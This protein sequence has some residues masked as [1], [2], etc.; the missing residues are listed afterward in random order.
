VGLTVDFS[1]L[2]VGW[3]SQ[4]SR[5]APKNGVE[6]GIKKKLNKNL[7]FYKKFRHLGG[8]LFTN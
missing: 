7:L 5:F 6:N 4:T 3:K 8:Q 1:F 2:N